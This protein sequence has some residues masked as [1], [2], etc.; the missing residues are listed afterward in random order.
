MQ[1]TK[2]F[3]QYFVTFPLSISPSDKTTKEQVKVNIEKTYSIHLL[4]TFYSSAREAGP[5]LRMKLW[6]TH[7]LCFCNGLWRRFG[8]FSD[9]ERTRTEYNTSLRMGVRDPRT[10]SNP[11]LEWFFQNDILKQRKKN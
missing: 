9:G 10:M 1:V 6:D 11:A 7:S 2:Y 3:I 4:G 8:A 5:A